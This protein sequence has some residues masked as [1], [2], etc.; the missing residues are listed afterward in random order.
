MKLHAL[1]LAAFL[2]AAAAPVSAGRCCTH[3]CS[4][5]APYTW[6]FC[7]EHLDC[8]I[9]EPFVRCCSTT[10]RKKRFRKK[11]RLSVEGVD[12]GGLGT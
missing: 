12:A 5:C 4:A 1:A 2:L 3:T 8:G 11:S 6:D 9:G 7:Q 10:H